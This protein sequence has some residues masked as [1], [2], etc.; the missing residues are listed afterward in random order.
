MYAKVCARA[1]VFH[2]PTSPIMT[3]ED[4]HKDACIR[5]K[6]FKF[7]NTPINLFLCYGFIFVIYDNNYELVH[8]I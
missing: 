2:P 1:K 4:I 6:E 3:D 8:D 5:S 7:L